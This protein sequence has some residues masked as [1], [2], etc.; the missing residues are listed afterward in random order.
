MILVHLK[1]V[2]LILCPIS[3][4]AY[5][6]FFYLGGPG[7]EIT[8]SLDQLSPMFLTV[9]VTSESGQTANST[10]TFASQGLY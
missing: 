4:D 1:S 10:V 9:I 2:M 5:T 7:P 6:F 8:V 3:F